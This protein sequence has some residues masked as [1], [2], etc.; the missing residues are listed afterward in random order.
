MGVEESAGRTESTSGAAILVAGGTVVIAILGLYVSGVPF[1]GALGLSSAIVVAV[2]VLA[3]LT[4][5]PAMLG[6]AKF[7]VLNRKDRHHLAE[8]RELEAGLPDE[9]AVAEHRAEEREQRDAKHEQSAFARWGRKVSDR[10]WPYGIAATLVLLDPGHPAVLDE[11]GPARR[12]HRSG[13]GLEPEGV[14]PGR[15]RV[16]PGRQRSAD[17]RRRAPVRAARHRQ[18]DPAD[19]SHVHAAEDRRRGGRPTGDHERAP[20]RRRSSPSSR[21]RRRRRRRPRIWSTG[22]ATTYSRGSRS[23]PTSSA[24]RPGTSTSPRRWPGG[25]CG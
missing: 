1:V 11:S 14:R 15:P 18:A 20:V 3:A 2:T 24:P 4:L 17:G 7:L 25:C 6:L 8:E 19:R 16:R 12:R 9:R 23:R 10:P 5:I 21:P 13:G 22:S